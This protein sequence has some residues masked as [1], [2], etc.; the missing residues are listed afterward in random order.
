MTK[1]IRILTSIMILILGVITPSVARDLSRVSISSDDILLLDTFLDDKPL[2]A[3]L[4]AYIVNDKLMLAVDPLFDSLALRYIREKNILRIWKD[5]SI[6][7]FKLSTKY[8]SGLWADDGFYLYLDHYTLSQLF[9]VSISYDS[10]TLKLKISTDSF[11]FPNQKLEELS[12]LRLMEQSSTKNGTRT[13]N[14]TNLLSDQYRLFTIPHGSFSLNTSVDKT[15]A[16]G[17]R[18][19]SFN[20]SVQ[21]VSDFLYHSANLTVTDYKAKE[22]TGRLNFSRYKSLPDEL[23]AGAF[24]SYS[25][26]D[27]NSISDNLTSNTQSGLG[28]IFTRAPEQYRTKNIGTTITEV[29]R[30]G[31]DAELYRNGQFIELKKVPLDGNLVFENVETQYGSNRYE[32]KLYGPFGEKEVRN[33][34]LT[35]DKN[36][37][38][39]G[40][41]AY[42]FYGLDDAMRLI[43]N[44]SSNSFTLNSAGASIS[45]GITDNWLI[46]VNYATKENSIE[47][48]DQLFTLKNSLAFPGLL[49]N[50]EISMQQDQGYAQISSLSGNAFGQDT[51][52]F[53]FESSDDYQ[54]DRIH[55]A[56]I[57]RQY[58]D[59]SYSGNSSPWYYNL[60]VNYLNTD[61]NK[62][63]QARN[64]LSRSIADIN[65]SHNLFYNQTTFD[66]D[67]T[68]YWN[69]T[70]VASGSLTQ[71]IRLSAAVNYRPDQS[72]IIQNTSVTVAWHDR[73]DLY[74]NLR[75]IYNLQQPTNKW[76]VNYNLS[77]NSE[78]FQL[79]LATN[80]DA[81]SN[82]SVGFG[83][84]FFLG[85]DHHNQRVIFSN[86]ISSNSATLSSHS[87]LD[88]NPNGWRDEGDWDL[89]GVTFTGIPA[90][91]NLKS[92]ET[93]RAILPGVSTN[94][95]FKFDAQWV[96]GTQAITNDFLLYTHPGA[97]IDVNMP[98]YVTTDFSGFV[99]KV[100]YYKEELPLTG[101]L[102]ELL[103][104]I[105]QVISITTSDV[106]GYYQFLNLTPGNYTIKI[107]PEYL[108]QS[109]YTSNTVGY[110]F[111]TPS[112]GGIIDLPAMT[113][114]KLPT[115]QQKSAESITRLNVNALSNEANVWLDQDNQSYGKV[116]SL[117][118]SGDYSTQQ[119]TFEPDML[120][121]S[122]TTREK[123]PVRPVSRE[124]LPTQPVV[125]TVLPPTPITRSQLPVQP[126]V[127]KSLTPTPI[128]VPQFPV[129][130]VVRTNINPTPITRSQLPV[131][132]ITRRELPVQPV[133]RTN[134][135]IQPEERVVS[136]VELSINEQTNELNNA[137]L[138]EPIAEINKADG[139]EAILNTENQPKMLPLPSKSS[140]TLQLG[141][142]STKAA[143]YTMLSQ[144]KHLPSS[145]FI[146]QDT[147]KNKQLFRVFLGN[148]EDHQ[149]ASAYKKARLPQ[150]INSFVRPLRE[151]QA[152]QQAEG[153]NMNKG[154]YQQGY[155]IQFIAGQN[156]LKILSTTKAIAGTN[157]V[158]FAEKEIKGEIWYCLISQSFINK[159]N[160]QKSL[161][162]YGLSAS[163]WLVKRAKFNN[164]IALNNK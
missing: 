107:T 42:D 17:H 156:K 28:F 68:K 117:A 34:Y 40:E 45:Y 26:G 85:Y 119:K 33:Q 38:A 47:Q 69:G 144:L 96:Y 67:V 108:N 113:I 84:R 105:N 22:A 62:S 110:Q 78:Q 25:F 57:E 61:N 154:A 31:W 52:N 100:N 30:P 125:R 36:A 90:W 4:D 72:N 162:A 16:N 51:F 64:T 155:V 41:V 63:W 153:D 80:Y 54:S 131:Q 91:D 81:E 75:G 149:Q 150:S 56:G 27:I 89:S 101:V 18:D 95:P 112:S 66:N 126:V 99:N 135:P 15:G 148:F 55:S 44:Q 9:D 39:K 20:Y 139:D 93:G 106:D 121:N 53:T 115:N 88:R 79:Q 118:S 141:V 157:E 161:D 1:H 87:Y 65:F 50:N 19:T 76:R 151:Q 97:Y 129:Q 164:I 43:N 132:P 32:I 58:A 77:W 152:E 37:L 8:S 109:G 103:N 14:G 130:S 102:I 60:G 24:D 123:L 143:A 48:S 49:F 124:Q 94:V 11:H 12:Y 23:I 160:A 83:I 133:T 7:D 147:S 73:L 46:G 142:F 140:F 104:N 29:A 35:L 136:P 2:I 128:T 163:A 114:K 145:P 86:Q 116:Y 137:Q 71:A 74:H 59:L 82:W 13:I 6:I 159:G 158:F 111:S 120:P 21:T 70:F 127:R 134:L 92:G 10:S 98:F 138:A 5:Q 122:P 3:A 146:Y